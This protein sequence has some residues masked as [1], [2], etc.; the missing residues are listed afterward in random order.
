M[1]R[2]NTTG[3][4]K[5]PDP[6]HSAGSSSL[7]SGGAGTAASLGLAWKKSSASTTNGNC[8]EVACFPAGV[9]AVR[10]SKDKEGAVLRFGHDS[11]RQF[12]DEVRQGTFPA[13]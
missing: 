7:V 9:V 3:R 13:R 10:D 2:D 12:L 11:W 5:N 8:V 4:H 6:G 1:G